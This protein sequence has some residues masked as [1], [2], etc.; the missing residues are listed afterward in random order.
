MSVLIG[1]SGYDYPEWKGVFYPQ[2]LARKDFL[3]YY[4]T[5]FNALE[6]NNTFYSMPTMERMQGFMERSENKVNFSI[7][8]HQS[9][10]HQIGAGWKEDAEVFQNAVKS[11][12]EKDLLSSVLF[13]FPQ[14]FHYNRENRFYLADLI[15]EFSGF[16]VVVEFRHREWLK[17]SVFD[18]LA[19]RQVP[20]V[21]CDMP[22]LK[23]LPAVEFANSLYEKLMGPQ[24][25]LRLHGR[26]ADSWYVNEGENNGSARYDYEY[27]SGELSSFVPVIKMIENA[28]KKCQVFFNNHPKGHGTKNAKQ[29]K[30]LLREAG[31]KN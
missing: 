8:A 31:A 30:E 18:G 1:T 21:F 14:S 15:K 13:Q 17:D 5:V 24:A 6:L 9:L 27:T 19:Q 25:Y 28:G 12:L 16:P 11:V 10:T 3:S 23:N 20:V 29:L 26:N 2:D 22:N 4:A 7:K